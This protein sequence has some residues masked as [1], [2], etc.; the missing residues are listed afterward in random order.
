MADTLKHETQE[1]TQK[2]QQVPLNC[3]PALDSGHH[4]I[5]NLFWEI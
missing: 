2:K 4:N 3:L 1:N 5:V